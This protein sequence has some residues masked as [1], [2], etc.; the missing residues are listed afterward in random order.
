MLFKQEVFT[1]D[2]VLNLICRQRCRRFD[3]TFV[4]EVVFYAFEPAYKNNQAL[5]LG[6]II[7]AHSRRACSAGRTR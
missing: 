5:D 6:W 2:Q 1:V 4:T 7:A 3:L